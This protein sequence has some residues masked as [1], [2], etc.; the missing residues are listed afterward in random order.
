[1]ARIFKAPSF[2][3][4]SKLTATIPVTGTVAANTHQTTIIGPIPFQYIVSEVEMIF[5]ADA[6]DNL[7]I[8]W[9]AS[10]NRATSTTAPPSGRNILGWMAPLAY[11]IGDGVTKRVPANFKANPEEK[12]IKLH[13]HN[14]NAYAVTI[15]CTIT[16]EEV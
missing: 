1:M 5:G 9:K 3:E 14:Q 6:A 16:I 2:E 15:N 11:F 7:R 12:Y 8:Y 4:V 13:A 10:R